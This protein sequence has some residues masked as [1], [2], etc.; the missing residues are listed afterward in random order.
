M[1]ST[2][3]TAAA[4]AALFAQ[5]ATSQ[6]P[7]KPTVH[8]I[9]T[10]GTISNT[11]AGDAARRT[12]NELVDGLPGIQ[13]VATVTNEQFSNVASGSITQTHWRTLATHIN[14]I[15]S[16]KPEV[17]GVVVTHGTDTMEETAFF[18]DLTVN[19]CKPVIVTGAMRQANAIG[20]DG[21]ANLFDAIV[22]AAA[23]NATKRG[24]MVLLNDEI[25]AARDVTK[26]HTSRPDAFG[27]PLRGVLGSVTGN[28]PA[29][30]RIPDRDACAPAFDV[31]GVTDFARVDIIYS[32]IGADS[33]LIR[34]AVDAGAKGIVMAGVGNGAT[35]TSQS[36]G[37]NY[38]RQKGVFVQSGSHTGS[39][40]V[41]SGTDL[42]VQK[43]RILLMLALTKSTDAA[44]VRELVRKYSG[45]Y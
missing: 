16:T 15:F 2:F 40:I 45:I 4:F 5:S 43:L 33:V 41:G 7:A 34:A 39:G 32:N 44:Q 35:V 8:V 9:A 28:R 36:S 30:F 37:L 18:L 13:N 17:A 6:T 21:P 19:P 26:L 1:R 3:V 29:F 24:T 22:T 23:P 14:E 10:G 27:A 11:G 31:A 25:F 38:A 12:G 42:N 20:A